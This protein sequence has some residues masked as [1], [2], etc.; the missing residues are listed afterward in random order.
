MIRLGRYFIV[1]FS[2]ILLLGS[3]VMSALGQG[4]KKE[5]LIGHWTFSNNKTPS[6]EIIVSHFT[7][8]FVL[9]KLRFIH[10]FLSTAQRSLPLPLLH[11]PESDLALGSGSDGER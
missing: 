1:S 8:F 4:E 7:A 10:R 2:V 6:D 11:V 5:D 3:R 9:S